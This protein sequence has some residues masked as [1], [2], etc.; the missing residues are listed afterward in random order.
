LF[1]EEYNT[2]IYMEISQGNSL[3]SNLKQTKLP[4]F[5]LYKIKGQEGRIGL[6][7]RD[8]YQYGEGGGT[9]VWE[10]LLLYINRKNE[11]C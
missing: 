1:F 3:C 11:N 6:A 8:W 2:Y 10:S 5:F 4:L 7:W 9:R